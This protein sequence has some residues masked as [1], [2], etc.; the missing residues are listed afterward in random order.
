M[1]LGTKSD[2]VVP[3]HLPLPI[4]SPSSSGGI[5][6]RQAV[7][8]AVIEEYAARN[9][10]LYMTCSAKDSINIDRLFATCV[11]MQW[12]HEIKLVNDSQP[13]HKPR[14]RCNIQ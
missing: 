11:R 7:P 4:S 13:K 1:L 8:T 3:D 6:S 5:P 12:L 9:N 2:L 14:C 10:M